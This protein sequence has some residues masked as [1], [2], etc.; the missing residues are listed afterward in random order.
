MKKTNM[1]NIII[2]AAMVLLFS[3]NQ[4]DSKKEEVTKTDQQIDTSKKTV[5]TIANKHNDSA[6][7]M[8][9]SNGILTAF[10][11]KNY[12]KLAS[13]IHSQLPVRFSPFST[14]DTASNKKFNGLDLIT[15]SREKKRIDW[16]SGFA[17][18]EKLTVDQYVSKYVYDKDYLSVGTRSFNNIHRG[19]TAE[20]IN[21]K[22]VYA[23]HDITEFFFPGTEKNGNMDWSAVRLVF[24]TKDNIRYLI[25]V[26]YDHWTP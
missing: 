19:G 26:V 16:G 14:V 4:S 1:R 7:L 3:C 24:D 23:G 9:I 8:L 10:K 6:Q 21:V 5:D 18:P 22:E 13:Y 17:E 20:Y 15:F 25:G 12:E 2:L 11:E